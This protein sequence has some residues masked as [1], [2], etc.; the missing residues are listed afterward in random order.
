MFVSP[1]T[2]DEYRNSL[3]EKLKVK[4]RVGLVMYA[5]RNGWWKP[6]ESMRVWEYESMRVTL[7]NKY[8]HTPILSYSSYLFRK[9][10]TPVLIQLP[11]IRIS[12]IFDKSDGFS[13]GFHFR[14]QFLIHTGKFI[15]TEYRFFNRISLSDF[16]RK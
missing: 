1:R 10:H 12:Q 4:S 9:I 2:V 6:E 16:F 14:S 7:I 3:F 11:E 13:G 5:I 8:S 15:K